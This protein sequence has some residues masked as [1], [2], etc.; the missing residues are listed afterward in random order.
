M[1]YLT[2]PNRKTPNQIYVLAT[3]N[4][5]VFPGQVDCT[6][7]YMAIGNKTITGSLKVVCVASGE[8]MD[9]DI[10]KDN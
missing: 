7:N 1:Y 4:T 10:Y 5:S 8:D 9:C 6:G 2:D 3:S